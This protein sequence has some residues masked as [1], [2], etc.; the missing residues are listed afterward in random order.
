MT[1]SACVFTVFS[2]HIVNFKIP[3]LSA[4]SQLMWNYKSENCY[5]YFWDFMIHFFLIQIMWTK[6]N[7]IC[8]TGLGC[9][10]LLFFLKKDSSNKHFSVKK[11]YISAQGNVTHSRLK[12]NIKIVWLYIFC[13]QIQN[14][15]AD[16]RTILRRQE[17]IVCKSGTRMARNDDYNLCIL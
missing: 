1:W 15:L 12:E 3:I 13:I 8:S 6:Y 5:I 9:F 10:F 17:R 7:S 4:L 16:D 2:R 14:Y 11:K